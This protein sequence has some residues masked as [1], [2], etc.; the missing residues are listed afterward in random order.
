VAIAVKRVIVVV[1]MRVVMVGVLMPGLRHVRRIHTV[2]LER[3]ERIQ[4][5]LPR[6]RL[7][8]RGPG[9]YGPQAI[10]QGGWNRGQIGFSEH[11]TIG[12]RNLRSHLGL[13]ID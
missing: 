1:M 11:Q 5:R 2:L 8:D 3:C 6:Y 7:H 10:A 12:H 13:A 9:V 4:C